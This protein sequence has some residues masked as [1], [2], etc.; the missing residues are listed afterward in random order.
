MSLGTL[1]GTWAARSKEVLVQVLD[2][3]RLTQLLEVKP[4]EWKGVAAALDIECRTGI[5]KLL[6]GEHLH[7][8]AEERCD[9]KAQ[10]DSLVFVR[11]VDGQIEKEHF[12]IAVKETV[13]AIA[14]FAGSD[15]I[16]ERRKVDLENSETSLIIFQDPLVWVQ[17]LS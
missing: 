16:P 14:G 11:K 2:V 15:K 5:G 7:E 8:V 10:E 13:E 1:P 6:F 3:A 4:G 12:D 9:Q 17:Y